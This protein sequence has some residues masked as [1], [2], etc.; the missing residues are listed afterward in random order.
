MQIMKKLLLYKKMSTE[1]FV[2]LRDFDL[3]KN[4][5][6]F[7][8]YISYISSWFKNYFILCFITQ[9][10]DFHRGKSEYEDVLQCNNA[11]S[12]ATPRGHQTPAAF[13]IEASGLEQV[14]SP[15]KKQIHSQIM[16]LKNMESDVFVVLV[17]NEVDYLLM[18]WVE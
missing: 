8:S 3:L 11:P 2:I 5:N 17:Q 6:I 1:I 15:V 18:F 9:D 4:I 7:Y 12:S 14:S 16:R 10:F 13:L